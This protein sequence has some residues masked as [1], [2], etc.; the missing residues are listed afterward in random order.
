MRMMLNCVMIYRK[1]DKLNLY[2][3]IDSTVKNMTRDDKNEIL[4]LLRS[5]KND[6]LA[7]E[8]LGLVKDYLENETDLESVQLLL[9]RL[10]NKVDALKVKIILNQIENTRNR[11]DKILQK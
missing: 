10:K 4:G 11:V 7:T 2:E 8:L 1:T 9:P 3:S 6:E 5:M